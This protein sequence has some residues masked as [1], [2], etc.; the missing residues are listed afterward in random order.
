MFPDFQALVSRRGK[1]LYITRMGYTVYVI[2][3]RMILGQLFRSI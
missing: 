2:A 1:L 3:E